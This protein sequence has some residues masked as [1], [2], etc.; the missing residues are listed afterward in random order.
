M[1][2]VYHYCEFCKYR[3]IVK[4]NLKRHQN[5]KHKEELI[6]KQTK[7]NLNTN[8]S[9]TKINIDKHENVIKNKDISKEDI[10]TCE[11][12]SKTYKTHKNFIDH[13]AKCIGVNSLTC[14]KCL[15]SFTSRQHK[16]THI[17]NH[18]KVK[19]SKIIYINI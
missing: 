9:V 3:T 14:P 17:K 8:V 7:S 11:K 15:K 4:C 2:T 16:H 6:E 10:H 13:V 12:C 19:E 18:C 5:T 1:A